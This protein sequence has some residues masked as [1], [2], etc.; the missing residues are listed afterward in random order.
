MIMW[1]VMSKE[2]NQYFSSLIGY[3]VI[4]VFLLLISLFMWVFVDTSVLDNRYA[5]LAQLFAVAPMILVFLI[6]ALTMRSI[7]EERNQ[8]TLEFLQTKP[9]SIS[10]LVIGKYLGNLILMVIALIPTL[11]FVYSVYQL[12]DPK[13]NIDLGEVMGSYIGLLSLSALFTA[14]GLFTSSVTDNQIVAFLL[15]VFICFFIY[16]GFDFASKLPI[17]FGNSDLVIQKLGAQ[18][19]YLALSQGNV[20]LRDMYYFVSMSSF[21]LWLTYVSLSKHRLQ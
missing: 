10:T 19:H 13:G 16:L 11:I 20:E 15:G 5:S 12:G 17:F 6:P 14:I 7:A 3:L 9:L 18:F 1:S 8:G 2:L 21:F 4:G